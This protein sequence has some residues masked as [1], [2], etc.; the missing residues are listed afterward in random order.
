MG[1]EEEEKQTTPPPWGW[2]PAQKENAHGVGEIVYDGRC[3]TNHQTGDRRHEQKEAC[4]KARGGAAPDGPPARNHRDGLEPSREPVRADIAA[5]LRKGP[6]HPVR[7]MAAGVQA[8]GGHPHRQAEEPLDVPR[9]RHREGG[10]HGRLPRP[11]APSPRQKAE[12]TESGASG[13]MSSS[14]STVSTRTKSSGQS[15]G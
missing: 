10:E 15:R 13:D 3:D 8:R 1:H 2:A 11:D 7:D 9:V 6:Q 5:A 12:T 4:H 14:I